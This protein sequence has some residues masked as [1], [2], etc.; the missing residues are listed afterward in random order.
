MML[1]THTIDNHLYLVFQDFEDK[2][3]KIYKEIKKFPHKASLEIK[4]ILRDNFFS[5]TLQRQRNYINNI[6]TYIDDITD[7]GKQYF[8][9]LYILPK[10]INIE[11]NI[12]DKDELIRKIE[13]LSVKLFQLYNQFDSGTRNVKLF[14]QN[15]GINFLQLEANFYIAK[16]DKLYNYLLNY[17]AHS[18]NKVICTDKRIG[19][20][21]DEINRLESNP[22]KNYQF[23][24]VAYQKELIWF[25]Y[26][27]ISF[28]RRLRI[29]IFKSQVNYEYKILVKLINKINNQLL[30]ISSH[31]NIIDENI[32]KE[33]LAKYLIQYKNKK[34]IK[35]NRRIYSIIESIF[36]TQLNNEVQFFMSIN[37]P[38]IFEEIVKKKL[39]N[40]F[41]NLFIGDESN[42]K[43]VNHLKVKDESLS[44]INF[45]L[46]YPPKIRQ[47]PDF[48]IKEIIEEQEIYH[49]IDAKYKLEKN[50]L[51]E[52]DIR[53][54][55]SYSI[56]FNKEYSAQLSN[57]KNI[58]KFIVFVK[59]ST[60]NL[61]QLDYITINENT[62]DIFDENIK[63][64]AI[65]EN[66]LDTEI[67][68][69]PIEVFKII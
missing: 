26:S 28:L 64:T 1:L 35:D 51:N 38:K 9:H 37:L 10:D 41:D 2:E 8:F 31:Q 39:S 47:Y 25:V 23:I 30:K 11:H 24:K 52:Q 57:Q 4:K 65:K 34:E 62:I 44:N 53:Q 16:L 60:I 12:T 43:I 18:T 40:Y 48:L 45:L 69:I 42:H 33:N 68:F 3:E 36:Y 49:V 29:E 22:L 5:D 56:L 7:N 58:K 32:S 66:L 6:S 27:T 19:V 15:K 17:K 21:I 20:E 50:I 55:L 46:K 67:I 54:V 13:L 61:N 59:S 63:Y 14:E